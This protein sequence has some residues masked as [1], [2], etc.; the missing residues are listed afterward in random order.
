MGAEAGGEAMS[1]TGTN[2]HTRKADVEFVK[3]CESNGT[4]WTTLEFIDSSN[5]DR[6]HLSFFHYD[7]HDRLLFLERLRFEVE[8]AIKEAE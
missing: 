8:K 3:S 1:S 7:R 2:F 6:H 4:H 5:Y